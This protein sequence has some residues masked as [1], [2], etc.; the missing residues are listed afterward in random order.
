MEMR[1]GHGTRLSG[2]H[3]DEGVTFS[4]SH[5]GVLGDGRLSS[6]VPSPPPSDLRYKSHEA[7]TSWSQPGDWQR[8]EVRCCRD[9]GY[10]LLP[11]PA[12]SEAVPIPSCC[13]GSVDIGGI[14]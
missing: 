4:N 2:P 13:F 7:E 3:L 10:F 5:K 6:Q 12:C 9:G 11:L 14:G 1:A 8:S